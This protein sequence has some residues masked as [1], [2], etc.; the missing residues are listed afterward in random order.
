MAISGLAGVQRAIRLARVSPFQLGTVSVEPGTRQII[1]SDG[2]RETLE[3]RVMQVLVALAEAQG[4]ILGRDDLIA[5]CW[6]GRI[7]GDNAIHRAVSKV[8]DLGQTF[9]GGEFR[10]ETITKV[11]YRMIV[12]PTEAPAVGPAGLGSFSGSW[13]TSVTHAWGRREF[14]A[15]GLVL[16]TASAGGLGW[17]ALRQNT[18]ERRVAALVDRADQVM[19]DG[20][21]DSEAQG[22]GF[23]REA[24]DVDARSAKAWGRLALANMA[25]AEQAP[26][27]QVTG[28]VTST[29]DAAGRALRLDPRQ[30]DALAALALLPPYFGDWFEAERR[31]KAVLRDHPDHLPTLDAYSF[32]LG[33]VGR[34]LEGAQIRLRTAAREPLH[35]VH[36][37]RLVYALW[38]LGRVGDADRAADRALQL[39]PKHPAVWFVRLWIYA[40]TGRPERAL[41]HVTD[42]AARPSLPPSMIEALS[43]SMRALVTPGSGD[44]DQAVD[45]LL[46]L[47][48]DGPSQ[49]VIAVMILT[50]LDRLDQAFAVAEA[51]LLET[52]PM[53]A[54]VRWYRGQVSINDQKH[55]KTNMLFVPV[56]APMRADPRFASLVDKVG[57]TDYWTRVGIRPDYIR[58]TP[59][60]A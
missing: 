36:Q 45:R 13:I 47:V 14:V 49:V 2:A 39:W 33:A 41:N 48:A 8:R 55:R 58:G 11:G 32:L 31:M 37:Y 50:A 17:W 35:V 10:L 3:P 22:A 5:M 7:V 20:A 23:L 51:Y 30:A 34:G 9:G 1:R 38:I 52:G 56:T 60:A 16:G 43:L 25:M 57:L 28:F 24:V 19:R 46:S 54:S 15:T 27:D 29:Q 40:F 26:P 18:Q 4:R 42:E 59:R 6:D 12:R 53:M 44:A 21:S